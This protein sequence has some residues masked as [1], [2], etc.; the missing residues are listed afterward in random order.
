MYEGH[1]TQHNNAQFSDLNHII[2]SI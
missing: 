1:D 2:L